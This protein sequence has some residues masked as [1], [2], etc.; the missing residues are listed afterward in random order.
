MEGGG[1]N[2]TMPAR[3]RVGPGLPAIGSLFHQG[4]TL[5]PTGQD[6]GTPEDSCPGCEPGI[7]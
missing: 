7:E 2:V 3:A 1:G 4:G 5:W 6:S